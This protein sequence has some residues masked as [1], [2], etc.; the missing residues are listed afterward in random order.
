MMRLLNHAGLA[1]SDL[2]RSLRFYCDVLGME[3]VEDHTGADGVRL[4]FVRAGDGELEIF[5]FPHVSGRA[6]RPA[7]NRPGIRHLSFLVDNME[8]ATAELGAKGVTFSGPVGSHVLPRGRVK[9]V[10]FEDPDGITLELLERKE[11]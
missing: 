8:R 4:V 2:D 3:L 5:G 9:Y 11:G 7:E 10:Y 1:V 6:V